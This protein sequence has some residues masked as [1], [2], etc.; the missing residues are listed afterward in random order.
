MAKLKHY[1]RDQI[2]DWFCPKPGY[3]LNF[4]NKTF[5]EFFDDHFEINIYSDA[6]SEKGTSKF[7]RLLAFIE[8]SPPHLVIEL[9]NLLWKQKN[10]E[11]DDE[12]E[13][14]TQALQSDAWS[15]NP[16]Y[17]EALLNSAALE[18]LPF[19]KLI[20]ELA[21]LPSHS[22]APHLMRIS[23]EWTLDTVEREFQRAFENLEKDPEA[24]V[25]A[26]CSMLESV[27]RSV[28]ISRQ[29]ELPR[30]LDIKSLYKEVREPLG[31]SPNKDIADTE[32]E[33]DV[34]TVLSALFNTVQGIGALRTHAGTAHGRERGFR[35]LD[36]RIARLAVSCKTSDLI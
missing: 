8:L 12:I 20:S 23:A 3:V 33:A 25:T 15:S 17:V 28:L 19:E 30:S 24:A 5:A 18:D 29:M 22:A 14:A 27:C 21:A 31:L 9:L 36:P 10:S 4:S 1:Q 2:R 11:R 35:S 16:E 26:A 13:R 32:I 6:F 34:R 7:N